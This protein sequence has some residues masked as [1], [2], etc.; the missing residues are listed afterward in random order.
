MT[1]VVTMECEAG[2]RAASLPGRSLKQGEFRPR[3][4]RYELSEPLRA[5]LSAKYLVDGRDA[6]GATAERAAA[7]RSLDRPLPSARAT[8]AAGT[9]RSVRRRAAA[10]LKLLALAATIV[11]F[12]MLAVVRDARADSLVL[13][14]AG[15]VF[16]TSQTDQFSFATQGPGELNV[17]LTDFAWPVTTLPSLTLDIMSGSTLLTAMQIQGGETTTQTSSA[18]VMLAA[19]GTYYAYLFGDAGGATDFGAYGV[20][21]DF[22]P[23]VAPV[24]LPASVTL[25]L[26][27]IATTAWSLRRRRGRAGSPERKES[28]TVVA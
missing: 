12:A 24:P 6:S 9:I 26:G 4:W 23:Q 1:E 21:G 16:G 20:V 5:F 11:L 27:G 3:A 8:G 19:A 14:N 25:L 15:D 2:R 10:V 13:A 18:S 22:V 28:V 17:T 7:V